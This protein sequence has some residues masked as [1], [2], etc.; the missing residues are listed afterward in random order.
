MSHLTLND[1]ERLLQLLSQVGGHGRAEGESKETFR[2]TFL[3]VSEHVRAFDPDVV[4]VVGE[5][6][7]GKSEL[8][9]AVL[10]E[11]LLPAISKHIQGVRLPPA[12][13][14][15]THWITGH[16]LGS[17]EFP[18]GGAL[19]R[20]AQ[21]HAG[22]RDAMLDLWLAYLVR[23]LRHDLD[24]TS[25]RVLAP[26]LSQQGGSADANYRAFLDARDEPVLALDRLDQSLQ[27]E[28]R[29]I[30]I[31][32]D[33]LD[34]LGRSDWQAMGLAT[35]GLISLWANYARRW[36]QIRAKVF[37]RV[38]LFHRHTAL[39]GAELAKLA[40]NRVE[41]S[42]SDRS[43]YSMLVKR[44]ANFDGE[45]LEYCQKARILFSDED[46]DLGRIPRLAKAEEAKP[47]VNRMIGE[48]MGAN[49]GKGI[50][51]NW[52]LDHVRDGRRKALPRPLVRLIE[53]AAQLEMEQRRAAVP[54]LLA[55]ASLRRALD[56]VSKEHVIQMTASECPWLEGVRQRLAGTEVPCGRRDIE[57]LL[58]KDWDRSWSDREGTPAPTDDSRDLVDYLVD[59]GIVRARADG[60][61][62]V[63]DLF[64]AG[65]GLKRRGGVARS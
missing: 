7:A 19:R 26:L 10:Q 58:A 53:R 43:L 18:D 14:Q 56:D 38:D 23:A 35:R 28:G 33:E 4:L 24:E 49:A 29:T 64:L 22:D 30:F 16:P 47:L 44:I 1:Q 5:R 54:K 32:Y 59:L 62:D 3:P 21:D 37:L 60:Q 13:P 50:T 48:W 12:S 40:A 63:P 2:R 42:W 9:R 41:I 45:L 51:F 27:K 61:V 52:L 6:G 65:L 15:A 8:F 17:G 39:A 57:R 20:F 55:H 11:Q 34:T 25:K 31:G 36:R 46:P